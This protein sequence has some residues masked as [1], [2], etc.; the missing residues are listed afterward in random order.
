MHCFSYKKVLIVAISIA[1]L[2]L[3]IIGCAPEEVAPPPPPPPPPP[4][5][6]SICVIP[7]SVQLAFPGMLGIPIKFTGSGWQPGEAIAIELVLPPGVDMKG[8]EPG[9][10]VALAFAYA[11]EA[12]KF[13]VAVGT[14][15][16]ILTIFRGDL[17]LTRPGNVVPESINP[18][19]PGTYTIKAISVA[20]GNSSETTI[21][22]MAPKKK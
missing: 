13:E 8:V 2:L 9:E 19:P 20:S 16:K 1:L 17:D 21:V 15:T 3:P 18:I 14:S 6:G 10:N 7:A 22:F 11:D 5:A 12:G 4:P